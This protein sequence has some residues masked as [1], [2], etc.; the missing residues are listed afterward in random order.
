MEI[1]AELDRY[2]ETFAVHK[3]MCALGVSVALKIIAVATNAAMSNAPRFCT[4]HI[5]RSVSIRQAGSV[6]LPLASAFERE[7]SKQCQTGSN[8][9]RHAWA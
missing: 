4:G 2:A 6:I 5:S 1:V 9:M 8:A 3:G 7:A